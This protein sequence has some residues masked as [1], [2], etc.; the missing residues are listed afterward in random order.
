M[1]LDLIKK[2][3]EIIQKEKKK[4]IQSEKFQHQLA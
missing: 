4:V 3:K 2:Q 1:S